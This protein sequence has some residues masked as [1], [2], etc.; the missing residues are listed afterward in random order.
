MGAITQR[1]NKK[2]GIKYTAQIRLKRAGGVVYQE[3]QRFDRKQIAQS[4]LKRR[5]NER[6]ESGAIDLAD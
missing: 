6:A 1:K 5:E 2:G 3:A 4:W